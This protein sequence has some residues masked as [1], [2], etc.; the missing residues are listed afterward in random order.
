VIA[1]SSAKLPVNTPGYDLPLRKLDHAGECILTWDEEKPQTG[2]HPADIVAQG[3]A[4]GQGGG[5][6]L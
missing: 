5:V 2:K 1:A 4:S 3:R 6:P